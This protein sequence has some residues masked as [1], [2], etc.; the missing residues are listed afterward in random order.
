MLNPANLPDKLCTDV[1]SVTLTATI[2]ATNAP[3]GEA[4]SAVKEVTVEPYGSHDF[5]ESIE[6]NVNVVPATC[7]E[8]GSKTVKCSRCDAVAETVLEAPGHAWGEWNETVPA[9]CTGKGAASRVCERCTKTETR[10]IKALGHAW[11]PWVLQTPATETEDGLEQRICGRC[12]E[13]QERVIPAGGNSASG[14]DSNMK[15]SIFAKLIRFFCKL[16][17][18]FLHPFSSIC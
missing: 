11:G 15:D 2:D 4:C 17:Q 14:F 3:D 8:N 9:T 5:D 10:E 6:G 1:Q 18:D 12:E 7:L 13:V 16:I